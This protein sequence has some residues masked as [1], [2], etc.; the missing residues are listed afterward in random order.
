M[1]TTAEIIEYLEAEKAKAYDLHEQSQG[2]QERLL[3]IVRAHT[4]EQLMEEIKER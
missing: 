2:K 3:H 4:I 1:K